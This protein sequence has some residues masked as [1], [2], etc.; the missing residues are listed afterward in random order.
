[1]GNLDRSV[2]RLKEFDSLDM[3][4]V[5]KQTIE[6]ATTK[7]DELLKQY[8]RFE[9]SHDGRYINSDLM[10]MVFDIYAES[11]ENREKYNLAVTNSAAC[12]TNEL[13]TRTI[14]ENN[15][16]RC[17]FV[18]GPYGAGKSYFIQSLFLG[19]YF[20]NNT[21]VY[22]GSITPPA[23]GK[24]VELA[25]SNNI[26]PM[27]VL[28]NPTLE[29][30]IS[31]IKQRTKETGRDVIKSEVVEKFADLH[32]NILE[33]FDYIK[34][35]FPQLQGEKYPLQFQIYNKPE[36]NI[37]EN[38]EISYNL[39]DLQ[40]GTREEVSRKYDEIIRQYNSKP[41]GDTEVCL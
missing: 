34:S 26:S 21:I 2:I 11:P 28:L 31:N 17:V 19:D 9:S 20:P 25:M 3:Q 24:K 16:K 29:L 32:S 30:S 33:L 1:M 18:C 5:Q 6:I 22:E 41:L 38:L 40:H 27:I 13:F 12:L 36:N 35:R 23:F 4:Q 37:P 15:Y 39:D 10:K 14:K 7:T 8:K